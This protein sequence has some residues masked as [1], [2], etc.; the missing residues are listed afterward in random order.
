L[1]GTGNSSDTLYGDA[2][3]DTL[4]G[5]NSADRLDGGSGND[6]LVWGAGDT[7]IGGTGTDTLRMTGTT[8]I[9]GSSAISAIEAIDMTTGANTVTLTA[10]DVISISDTDTITVTGD[11]GDT[12]NIGVGGWSVVNDGM[13]HNIYTSGGATLVV[14]DTITVN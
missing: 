8:L 12:L 10:A 9:L 13:G 2:G 1:G 11:A 7:I 6:V 5:G 3:N 14:D 4:D